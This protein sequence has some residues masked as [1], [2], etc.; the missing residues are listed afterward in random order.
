MATKK[1][2]R[3]SQV[4]RMR[5]VLNASLGDGV[6]KLRMGIHRT[7]YPFRTLSWRPEQG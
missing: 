5:R 7:G 3:R 6:T 1:Q 2:N 4:R